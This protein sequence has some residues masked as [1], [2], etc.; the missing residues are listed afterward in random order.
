[1]RFGVVHVL[2]PAHNEADCIAVTLESLN[3]QTTPVASV[4]VVADNCT[5]ATA[6]IATEHGADVIATVDNPYMK[7]GALNQGLEHLRPRI[8]WNDFVLIMDAD[9]R[10]VEGWVAAALRTLRA[11][12]NA[13]AV[14]ATFLGEPDQP[15]LIHALQRAEYARFARSISR[16]QARAQVLSGVATLLPNATL[17]AV[18]G[19]RRSGRLAS[20]PGIYQVTAATEDIELTLALR[21]LGY[22]PRA[23]KACR[24]FTDTMDSWSAL[25][26]QRTRWQR[27][28]LDAVSLYGSDRRTLPYA[29][30]LWGMYV[31]SLAPPLYVAL[32]A[33]AV[34]LT[35][36]VTYNPLW[37]MVLPLFSFE[38]WWTVRSQGR[39]EQLLAV[40]LLPEWLYDNWR[41][42]VYWLALLQRIRRTERVWIPT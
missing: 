38:R 28:M 21:K 23:P 3:A 22:R 35:G 26:I 25:K 7:A 9:S 8:K 11:H 34:L 27:G 29:L 42:G 31:V 1:M 37:L 5:D 12:R 36:G 18:D 16:R 24:A 4:L 13:G 33:A 17:R 15:G 10:L 32:L 6:A 39:Q 41:A 20:A 2:I 19:A 30:R 40:L 14:C